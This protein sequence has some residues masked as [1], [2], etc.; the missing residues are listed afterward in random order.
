M[1]K[2]FIVIIFQDDK[3]T[4]TIDETFN[5]YEIALKEAYETVKEIEEEIEEKKKNGE[6][7]DTGKFWYK[8]VEI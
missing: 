4:Y 7:Y 8:I 3:P 2:K 1:D 6:P 5:D